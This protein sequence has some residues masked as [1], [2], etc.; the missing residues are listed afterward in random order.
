MTLSRLRG[1]AV[2]LATTLLA[3]C[4]PLQMDASARLTP[5]A[6]GALVLN[7]SS[8]RMTLAATNA[9]GATLVVR[10]RDPGPRDITVRY[11][12]R[13]TFTGGLNSATYA[14]ALPAGTYELAQ[15]NVG[16]VYALLTGLGTFKV[17]AGRVTYLGNVQQLTVP[18][19]PGQLNERVL[20]AHEGRDVDAGEGKALVE[21]YFPGFAPLLAQPPLGWEDG[22]YDAP[23]MRKRYLFVRLN[24]AGHYGML[25]LGEDGILFGN[26]VG[27]IRVI[28]PGKPARYLDTGVPH[29]VLALARLADGTLV[30]GGEQNLFRF[31]RDKGR[32][33]QPM[34][35]T[36]PYGTVRAITVGA[37]GALYVTHQQRERVSVFKGRADSLQW[38][39]LYTH[40]AAGGTRALVFPQGGRLLLVPD[41]R[42]LA[43]LDLATGAVTER[44]LP[45]FARSF[46]LA[47]EGR[48]YCECATSAKLGANGVV[49]SS[50]GGQS[51]T[52]LVLPKSA[53]APYFRDARHGITVEKKFIGMPYF[54]V[55]SDGGATWTKAGKA[56]QS[57]LIGYAGDNRTLFA[58]GQRG[59][60]YASTDDGESWELADSEE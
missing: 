55:T 32:T 14:G 35:H 5:T 40:A 15:I 41:A 8:N 27:V 29:A 22:S 60:L 54:H 42:T 25:D 59:L 45:G 48:L 49:A 33:W 13:D 20:L 31:S 30:A 57:L 34:L 51:W 26:Q 56:P 17:E 19:A 1:V 53:D 16:T 36:L 37:D 43:T 24:G 39:P 38:T 12:L 9:S 44:A 6:P 10:R 4:T 23:L 50:D 2:L 3:A 47:P 52:P 18:P 21:N 7:M 11:N 58:Q 28:R 46:T